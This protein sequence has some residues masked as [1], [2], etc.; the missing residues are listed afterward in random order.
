[1]NKSI[2]RERAIISHVEFMVINYIYKSLEEYNTDLPRMITNSINSHNK[3]LYKGEQKL[4]YADIVIITTDVTARLNKI[5]ESQHMKPASVSD[6]I[7]RYDDGSR[8]RIN[9]DGSLTVL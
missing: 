8:L 9:H 4:Q 1:M 2:T 6:G 3:M 5:Q 7:I